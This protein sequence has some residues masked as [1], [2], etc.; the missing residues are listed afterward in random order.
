MIMNHSSFF[1]CETIRLQL[2]V[3]ILIQSIREA[4]F[5]LDREALSQLLSM[6]FFGVKLLDCNWMF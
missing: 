3:L 2:D 4:D 5:V 1:W 6:F